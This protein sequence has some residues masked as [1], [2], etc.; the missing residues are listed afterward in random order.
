LD[1]LLKRIVSAKKDNGELGRLIEDYMPFIKKAV[2][3]AGNLG[4]EYDDRLSVAM[5]TFMNCVKQYETQRGGF[6]AFAKACI[7]NRLIDESRKQLRYSGRVIPL[8]PDNDDE[9]PGAIEDMAS[10]STYNLEEERKNLS[11]EIELLS[12]HIAEYGIA[13]KELPRICPKQERSR[14]QCIELGRAVASS[15]EMRDTLMK[16]RRLSQSELARKFGISEKTIEK[17]RKYIV[18]V[19]VLLTGD[20][21][22]IRAFLPQYKEV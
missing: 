13:F 3:D 18:T 17:H 10:I 6:M 19:A 22:L 14:K 8:F 11:A 5:L 4:M 7:R 21:P 20:Y 12:A 9:R 1:V 2:S 16:H 15:D